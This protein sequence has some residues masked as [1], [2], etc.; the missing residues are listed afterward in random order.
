MKLKH[1]GYGV[2]GYKQDYEN[3]LWGMI[4]AIAF[5]VTVSFGTVAAL[6]LIARYLFS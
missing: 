1:G 6:I 4:A 5:T 2:R 3:E